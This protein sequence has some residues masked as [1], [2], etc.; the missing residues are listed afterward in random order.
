MDIRDLPIWIDRI[1][2]MAVTGPRSSAPAEFSFYQGDTYWL[3]LR[4]LDPVDDDSLTIYR[5]APLRYA[6]IAAGLF[7]GKADA[8]PSDGFWKVQA[9][10]GGTVSKTAALKWNVGKGELHKAL[11][12]LAAVQEAGGVTVL[13]SG[14]VNFWTVHGPLVA[15]REAGQGTV[16]FRRRLPDAHVEA[17][18]PSCR[19]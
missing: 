17:K 9:T 10:W 3:K 1:A 15:G 16:G 7:A 4:G 8:P 6:I 2:R 13:Q 19:G 18:T 11:N 14:P 12:E 5:P